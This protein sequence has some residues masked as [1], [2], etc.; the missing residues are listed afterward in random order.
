MMDSEVGLSSLT[1]R[2]LAQSIEENGSEP[3]CVH[4]RAT[5]CSGP[6][7]GSIATIIQTGDL[8]GQKVVVESYHLE[9]DE[10]TCTVKLSG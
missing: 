3:V 10:V 7:A 2:L 8:N 6:A 4:P 5:K 1:R 9:R